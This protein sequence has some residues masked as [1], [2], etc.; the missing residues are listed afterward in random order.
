VVALGHVRSK[1]SGGWRHPE[2]VLAGVQGARDRRPVAGGR[3]ETKANHRWRPQ[4][5]RSGSHQA[6]HLGPR[7]IGLGRT[8]VAVDTGRRLSVLRRPVQHRT[9]SCPGARR[10]NGWSDV[11]RQVTAGGLWGQG[12]ACRGSPAILTRRPPARRP[13]T[14]PAGRWTSAL[15]ARMPARV[16]SSRLAGRPGD[17][18]GVTAGDP[19]K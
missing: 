19:A 7:V 6:A 15:T 11:R 1:V 8:W 10:R 5:V 3:R 12:V 2:D 17:R 14:T 16:A 13:T 4:P 9:L 18:E